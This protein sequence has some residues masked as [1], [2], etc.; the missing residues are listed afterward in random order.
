M[1]KLDIFPDIVYCVIQGQI[2]KVDKRGC[3]SFVQAMIQYSEVIIHC[4]GEVLKARYPL[5]IEDY[6]SYLARVIKN[7]EIP[8]TNGK[9]TE[10]ARDIYIKATTLAERIRQYS[11]WRRL[12]D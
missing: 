5:E 12:D 8:L 7:T 10:E 9:G 2:F 6:G 3:H 11:D 1:E 4:N